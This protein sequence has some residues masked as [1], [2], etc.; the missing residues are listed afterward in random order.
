MIIHPM[1]PSNAVKTTELK[2]MRFLLADTKSIVLASPK[3]QRSR[4]SKSTHARSE[5]SSTKRYVKKRY[6]LK[7]FDKTKRLNSQGLELKRN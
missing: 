4:T 5:F 6:S 3:M 7:S 1:L 2:Q